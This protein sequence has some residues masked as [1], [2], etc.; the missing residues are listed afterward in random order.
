MSDSSVVRVL[1][2]IVKPDLGVELW[3]EV[4][5]T[6]VFYISPHMLSYSSI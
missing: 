2:Q 4:Y 6:I 3:T 5:I 1:C